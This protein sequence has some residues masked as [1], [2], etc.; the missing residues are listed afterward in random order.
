MNKETHV[1]SSR[2]AKFKLHGDLHHSER[3]REGV[4]SVYPVRCRFI[5]I[6]VLANSYDCCASALNYEAE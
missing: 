4:V 1:A 2:L 5:S 6:I 3:Q